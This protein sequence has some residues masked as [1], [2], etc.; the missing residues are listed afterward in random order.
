MNVVVLRMLASSPSWRSGR[1]AQPCS[2]RLPP[3]G[4][5][6]R[7][8]L[9]ACPVENRWLK[10]AGDCTGL[11]D[12]VESFTSS[13]SWIDLRRVFNDQVITGH[14]AG[15]KDVATSLGFRWRDD[16]PGGDV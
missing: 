11:G 12:E 7:R 3:G 5:V 9:L 13:E 8:V 16:S 4:A 14:A 2:G 10:A 15:L 1:V 6:L